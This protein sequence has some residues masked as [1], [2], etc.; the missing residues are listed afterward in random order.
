MF[1]RRLEKTKAG[2]FT[3]ARQA[4]RQLLFIYTIMHARLMTHNESMITDRLRQTLDTGLSQKQF[5]FRKG[6]SSLCAID[7]VMRIATEATSGVRR[8]EAAKQYC[9]I[10][11]L[12]IKD[13][14]NSAS[15]LKIRQ[16]TFEFG[17]PGYQRKNLDDYLDN[18]IL[19]YDADEAV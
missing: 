12:D 18:R 19:L 13:A 15:W 9:A 7:K 8:R 1:I 6:R 11:T 16:A 5:G 17:V 4:T 14:F 2:Y 10:V 3:T